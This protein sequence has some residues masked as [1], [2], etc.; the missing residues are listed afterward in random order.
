[1]SKSGVVIN[2]IELRDDV[3]RVRQAWDRVKE[4]LEDTYMDFPSTAGK[5]ELEDKL[6]DQESIVLVDLIDRRRAESLSIDQAIIDA[7]RLRTRPIPLTMATTIAGLAPLAFSTATLWPPSA[8]AM[9]SG[10]L[11]STGLTLLVAPALY[12]LLFRDEL[13]AQTVF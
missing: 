2:I 4:A 11:A 13:Q 7:V 1:M 10:P 5:P 6:L 8:W 9:V 12:R 3:P